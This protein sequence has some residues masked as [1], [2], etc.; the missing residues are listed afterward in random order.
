MVKVVVLHGRCGVEDSQRTVCPEE[1][2]DT[3]TIKQ[4][5]QSWC[6]FSSLDLEGVVGSS[7]IQVMA[8]AAD[9]Q[10]QLLYAG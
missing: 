7:V 5:W 2:K 9:E 10:G 1:K 8:E 4:V 6:V 3:N